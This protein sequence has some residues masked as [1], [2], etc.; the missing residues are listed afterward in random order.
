MKAKGKLYPRVRGMAMAA[1]HHP[2]GGGRH[3]HSLHKS[4]S[5]SRTAPPGAKVGDIASRKTGRKRI[6]KK[7]VR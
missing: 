4:K 5:I 2:F 6:R 3:Q 1:V 7:V